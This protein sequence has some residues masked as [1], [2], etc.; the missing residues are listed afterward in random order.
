M[1]GAP[2]S[3]TVPSGTPTAGSS[4]KSKSSAIREPVRQARVY[5]RGGTMSVQASS[6]PRGRRGGRPSREEKPGT[7]GTRDRPVKER[8]SHRHGIALIGS[9]DAV[10]SEPRDRGPFGPSPVTDLL[11]PFSQ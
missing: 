1:E 9:S 6:G 4:A 10:G 2:L 8:T 3:S 7:R 11:G 5:N